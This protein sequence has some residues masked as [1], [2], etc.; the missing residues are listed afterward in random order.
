MTSARAAILIVIAGLLLAGCATAVGPD[1]AYESGD[2]LAAAL[3]R[4]GFE[5]C[6]NFVLGPLD[7]TGF[8]EGA[9]HRFQ[10]VVL[11]DEAALEE[12][13]IETSLNSPEVN[14][15]QATGAN[16]LVICGSTIAKAGA[17]LQFEGLELCEQVTA[18]IGGVVRKDAARLTSFCDAESSR[19][20]FTTTLLVYLDRENADLPL[21]EY[22]LRGLNDMGADVIQHC[23]P[24]YSRYLEAVNAEYPW[25]LPLIDRE[26]HL[27]LRTQQPAVSVQTS[28]PTQSTVATTPQRTELLTDD[29]YEALIYINGVVCSWL[30]EGLDHT[31]SQVFDY[32]GRRDDGNIEATLDVLTLIYLAMSEQCAT[33]GNLYFQSL[34]P[35]LEQAVFEW[36]SDRVGYLL[37]PID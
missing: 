22:Y 11:S 27:R 10:F 3:E 15:V 35:E 5:G 14:R 2:D 6:E 7:D 19:W 12:R 20:P 9:D 36:G 21:S 16:W 30:D 28:P 24:E 29:D 31:V 32:F 8:C 33:K 1:T 17:P 37:W 18:S 34:S 4:A 26:G 23:P 13:L 25:A